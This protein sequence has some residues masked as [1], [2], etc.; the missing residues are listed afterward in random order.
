M[1]SSS[2]SVPKGFFYHLHQRAWAKA[3]KS[4]QIWFTWDKAHL[5]PSQEDQAGLQ[6]N[7][8]PF[9]ASLTAPMT[10]Q[11]NRT[12]HTLDIS[13]QNGGISPGLSAKK[14]RRALER[15]LAEKELLV[16]DLERRDAAA[17]LDPLNR[18]TGKCARYPLG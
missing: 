1:E 9:Q 4:R 14:V 18:S 17:E 11:C 6:N 8:L 13:R 16:K 5:Y 7:A 12:L 10:P 15:I 3:A 2:V